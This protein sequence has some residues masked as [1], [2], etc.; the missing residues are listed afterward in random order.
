MK[1]NSASSLASTARSRS[2]GADAL[3]TLAGE[4]AGATAVNIDR[5]LGESRARSKGDNALAAPPRCN[6]A[7]REHFRGRCGA[8]RAAKRSARPRAL[9]FHALAARP[10]HAANPARQ[11]AVALGLRPAPRMGLKPGVVQ[12]SSGLLKASRAARPSFARGSYAACLILR[13]SG[14]T[15]SSAMAR[16]AASS[17]STACP[18]LPRRRIETVRSVASLRPTTSSAGT[19]ASECSRTL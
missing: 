4:L 16:S 6:D 9:P 8:A 15:A 3:T 17:A 5:V 2:S 12:T 14:G 11:A 10:L 7:A 18:S 13:T 19:L 1:A